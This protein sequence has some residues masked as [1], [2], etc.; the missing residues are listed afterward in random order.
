MPLVVRCLRAWFAVSAG[1]ALVL[2]MPPV[3]VADRVELADGR[4]LDGSFAMVGGVADNPLEDGAAAQPAAQPIVVCDDGLT[5]TMVSKRQV[6][7]TERSADALGTE[8]LSIP[9]LVPDKGRRVAGIGSIVAV[10][11]F[12][13]YGRRTLSL[14]TANGRV[15]LVQGITEITPRWIKVEGLQTEKP[16]VLDMRMA[17]SSVPRAVLSRVIATHLDRGDSEQRLRLVRLLLQSERYADARAELDEVL[18]DFPDLAHLAVERRTLARL[19]AGQMHDELLLRGRAGQDRFAIEMLDAFPVDDAAPEVL[20][21]VKESRDDYR[22]RREQATQLV[23]AVRE[24]LPGIEDADDRAAAAA[25]VAEI[26]QGLSF[27]TLGR[28]ATF[29]QLGTDQSM[30]ADRA[31]ALAINGWLQ[32]A[33]NAANLKAALSAVRVRDLV[34]DYLRADD[35]GRQAVLAK[36]R[37]EEAFDAATIAS[38]AAAMRPPLDP[39]EPTAPGLFELAVPQSG[40]G[41]D[42]ICLVQL[43]PEYDPLRRYPAVVTLHSAVSSPLNQIEWWAGPPGR[44]GLRRG[45][46]TRQ[47]TIVIAPAWARQGQSSYEA[48]A[49]EHAAVLTALRAAL[50]RFAIDTDR[51]FLSGHSLGGDAAWDIALAHPD[52]WAGLMLITPTADRYVRHY[53]HNARQLPIYVVGGE[54]DG[55]TI[56]RNAVDLDRYLDR[57]FDTTYVE[58]RGRGHEHYSDEI[59]RLFDWMGRKR[60]TFFPQAIDV[61]SMR[62]WDRFFWWVEMEAAPPRT[63]VLPTNWPPPPNTRPLSIEAKVGAN[64]SLAVRCGAERVK[65]WLAPELIDFT[66]PVTVTIDSKQAHSGRIAPDIGLLLEDLRLRADRQHPFWAVVEATKKRSP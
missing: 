19:A 60:R 32:T 29:E 18:R 44:D 58:Y 38:L 5:R 47:G 9:Q 10:T 54:F 25:M 62:P 53:W 21:A 1:V 55:T 3:A 22:R 24:R 20:Q 17:T 13:D 23:A 35:A 31:V 37:D 43:P 39:P 49:R 50:R 14:A 27:A 16:L 7:R 64:N 57:G 28:L 66:R 56:G 33:G 40:G 11:P 8:R 30:S 61:V 34:R 4:V 12:D 52:L 2:A 45:Q 15:D 48:S 36:L 26:E 65:V 59:L 63:V 6:V 46:A 51:V 41:P 42:V